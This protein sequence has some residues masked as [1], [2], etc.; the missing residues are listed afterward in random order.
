MLNSTESKFDSFANLSLKPLLR[1]ITA[2]CLSFMQSA[3]ERE[4]GEFRIVDFVVRL[5]QKNKESLD[6]SC[7]FPDVSA[8]GSRSLAPLQSSTAH[9]SPADDEPA[10]EPIKTPTVLRNETAESPVCI[11][12]VRAVP[13]AM[14]RTDV[15]FMQNIFNRHA[16]VEGPPCSFSSQKYPSATAL[17]SALQ[18]AEAPIV[19]AIS[20]DLLVA[21]A[22]VQREIFRRVD[23]DMSGRITFSECVSFC[24][25]FMFPNSS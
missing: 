25:S 6:Q 20:S 17:I 2:E 9:S 22:D 11:N 7:R 16:N 19:T 15:D 24:I 18:E 12:F 5:L 14:M 21:S 13:A 1:F 23:A 10:S 3:T 4:A 8:H